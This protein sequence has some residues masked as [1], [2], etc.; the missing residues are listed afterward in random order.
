MMLKV[1]NHF[2]IKQYKSAGRRLARN[3]MCLL[4][5]RLDRNSMESVWDWH[6]CG[7][8][9]CT[10]WCLEGYKGLL[11]LSNFWIGQRCPNVL[12][13]ELHY[14][15]DTVLRAGKM[16]Y[17][18]FQIWT[19]LHKTTHMRDIWRIR[20]LARGP[21]GGHIETRPGGIWSLGLGLDTPDILDRKLLPLIFVSCDFC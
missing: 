20:S 17:R 14:L 19:N 12:V 2:K 16:I 13:G 15:S 1:T 3:R 4:M 8:N 10:L 9:V 5:E 18:T 6:S 11:L 21:D 7:K